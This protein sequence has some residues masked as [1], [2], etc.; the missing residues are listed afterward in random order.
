MGRE[1]SYPS[2][3]SPTLSPDPKEPDSG[4]SELVSRECR[5]KSRDR[6]LRGVSEGPRVRLVQTDSWSWAFV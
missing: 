3:Y 2:V 5:N 6:V 4:R 1:G